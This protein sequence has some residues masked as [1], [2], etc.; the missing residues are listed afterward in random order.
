MNDWRRMLGVI[1]ALTL[2]LSL[3]VAVPTG[4]RSDTTRYIVVFSATQDASGTY[5]LGGSFA[6]NHQAALSLVQSA[7]GTVTADLSRQIGVMLASSTNAL[8]A[9]VLR[10]SSL[11]DEVG[12]DFGW[13]QYPTIQEALDSGQVT[14]VDADSV[15][16]G[17]PDATMDPLEF[18]QWSMQMIHAP[19]AHEIQAGARA[20]EVGILDTGIDGLH[21]DFRDAD[22]SNVD[23]ASGRDFVPPVGLGHPDPCIDN[24]FHGTHVAGIVAARANMLGVVGVAPNVKLIPVKVCDSTGFCYASSAVAG[25]TYAGDAQFEVINMSFFVDD[26]QLLGSTQFKCMNDPMQRAFRQAVERAVQYARNQG[27][28]PVAA[29]G[30]SDTDLAH[31][32]AGNECD[33]V[34]AESSGVVG[35]MALGAMSQKAGYS[36]YGSGATDVAAP[37]GA[38]TTGDCFNTVLSTFPGDTYACIQG[39]SMASPHAA[40]V[41]ALIVSQFGVLGSDGDVVMS[42][43]KVESYLQST[44]IDIG[45]RGYDECFGN[46]RI[47]ALRAVQHETS[48]AYDASAPFCPEYNE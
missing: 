10:A 43:T 5:E 1:C 23:C 7:G 13:K 44:T 18:L 32:P 28:T 48:R 27:V 15:P 39:T 37:G 8:F 40:G 22:G 4:A 31:N 36:S 46:G 20:V 6:L 12:E 26:D 2:A 14:I 16:G 17:G 25:I 33:V 42:P 41:A 11:V 34:P 35:T 9:D 24:N 29:L 19:E 30:N 45:L 21:A 38:G 3:A 47:D